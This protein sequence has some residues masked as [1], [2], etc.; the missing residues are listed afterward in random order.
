MGQQ[1]YF[2]PLNSIELCPINNYKSCKLLSYFKAPDIISI[3]LKYKVKLL[4]NDNFKV[5]RFIKF[6][7]LFAIQAIPKFVYLVHVKS[8]FNFIILGKFDN[9]VAKL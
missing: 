7:K 1:I 5:L 6:F 9:S 8:K 3:W 4:T 2:I